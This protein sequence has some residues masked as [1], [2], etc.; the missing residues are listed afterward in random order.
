[1]AKLLRNRRADR[2]RI[3]DEGFSSSLR[4]TP[5]PTLLHRYPRKDLHGPP[6]APVGEYPSHAPPRSGVD[7]RRRLLGWPEIVQEI[8]PRSRHPE[9]A[10]LRPSAP[11]AASTGT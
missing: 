1:M 6:S 4:S 11:C 7:G 2:I 10:L 9:P 5:T 3:H 8:R